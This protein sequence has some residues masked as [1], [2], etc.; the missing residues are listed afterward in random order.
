MKQSF[1]LQCQS[2]K[3]TLEK[4]R[5]KKRQQKSALRLPWQKSRDAGAPVCGPGEDSGD[6]WTRDSPPD[7]CS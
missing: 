2:Y 4:K 3:G 1:F 7:I 6:K 5:N